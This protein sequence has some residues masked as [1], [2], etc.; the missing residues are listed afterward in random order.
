MSRTQ[1]EAVVAVKRIAHEKG[2]QARSA[3]SCAP[4]RAP[5]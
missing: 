3:A 4:L 5:G 1:W 2:I